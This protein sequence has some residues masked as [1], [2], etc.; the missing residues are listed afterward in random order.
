R[1][2]IL[3]LGTVNAP[4]QI[5]FANPMITAIKVDELS[6]GSARSNVFQDWN[7]ELVAKVLKTL[8]SKYKLDYPDKE[9]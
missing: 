6:F 8:R 4:V 5:N 9:A 3:L 1:A 7:P 2:N